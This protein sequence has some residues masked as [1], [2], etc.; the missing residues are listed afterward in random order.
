MKNAAYTVFKKE[1]LRFFGDKRLAFSTII[2]PGLLIYVVYSI[3]GVA[4]VS[5]STVDEEYVYSAVVEN[6][7]EILSDMFAESDITIT[8]A[9]NSYSTDE[10]LSLLENGSLD[11]YVVFP[12]NFTQA[13]E[14]CLDGSPNSDSAETAPNVEIYYNSASTASSS[15]YSLFYSYL[16]SFE[17]SISNVF[18]INQTADGQE[19]AYD[20]ATEEETTG[21][22]LSMILPLVLMTLLYGG[23]TSL[24]PESIAGEKDRGTIAS[25]LITPIKRGSIAIGKICALA[26]IAL[27]SGLSSFLGTI[28][29]MPSLMSG[30]GDYNFAQYYGLW[31]YVMLVL[32]MLS[33]VLLLVTVI[34]I[35]STLAK[36][37]KEA[38]SY[39]APLMIII[40]VICVM[41]MYS[42]GEG[43]SIAV[44]LVPVYNTVVSMTSLFSFSLSTSAFAATVLSNTLYS[45][46]GV[47]VMEKLFDSE[48]IMFSK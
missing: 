31:D 36:T 25:L 44:Y 7:P 46:V 47:L 45:L 24:A 35:L 12:D 11:L 14:N 34:S 6:M 2:L 15:A 37:T 4:L 42:G 39:S 33:T 38:Q 3:L 26:I 48:K 28:L 29:S 13:V 21:S 18:N 30:M 10:Y 40:M 5:T 20:V 1:M 41:S 17:Q 8:T 16:N 23:C 9:D 19:V 43:T 27:L 32:I 22:V